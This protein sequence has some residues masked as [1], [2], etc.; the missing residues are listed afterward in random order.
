MPGLC[1][2]VS[3]C[4]M[5]LAGGGRVIAGGPRLLARVAAVGGRRRGGWPHESGRERLRR[6]LHVHAAEMRK[7]LVLVLQVQ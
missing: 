3:V 5:L 1:A 4:A 2:V 6:W 7:R